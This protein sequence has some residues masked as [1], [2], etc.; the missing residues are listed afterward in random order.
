MPQFILGT[1]S[2]MDSKP[3]EKTLPSKSRGHRKGLVGTFELPD[4]ADADTAI[5]EKIQV[6][7]VIA[8][9]RFAFDDLGTAGTVDLGFFKRNQDGTYTV[10]DA[11]AMANN[12]DVNAAAVAMTDYR[13]SAKGIETTGQTVW[14]LAG[15]S[16]RP[17]YG[18]LYIGITTDTGTTAAGTVAYDITFQE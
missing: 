16:A 10:V 3:F 7:A 11:D 14:E 1:V 8:T 6:D 18:D 2:N 13:Y 17:E 4:T 9:F 5:F 12:I 15:L